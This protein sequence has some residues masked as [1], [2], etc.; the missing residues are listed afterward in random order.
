MHRLH[1]LAMSKFRLVSPNLQGKDYICA[2]I[3]GHFT[4]LETQL[5]SIGFDARVDRLFSLGDLIDRGEESERALEFLAQPWFQAILGNHEVMLIE[6]LESQ[7][8]EALARWFYWGG[9]W[10]EGLGRA[11][12]QAYYEHFIGLPIA[13]ELQLGSERRVGLVHAELPI[14][15][16]WDAVR[17]TLESMPAGRF[18]T[19]DPRISDLLWAKTQAGNAGLDDTPIP[20]AEGIDHVF[21]GHTIVYFEPLTLGNRTFLDLG[22]YETGEIGLIDVERFLDELPDT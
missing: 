17:R 22:S 12:L 9:A 10:A 14:D 7:N 19:Y 20:Q 13:M 16:N 2:D 5:R 15:T 11:E 6:A 1:Y 18:D 4:L 8:R 3:H 21:H